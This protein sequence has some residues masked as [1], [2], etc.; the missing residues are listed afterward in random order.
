[1]H[2]N[3]LLASKGL[4]RRRRVRLRPARQ[5]AAEVSDSRVSERSPHQGF[6]DTSRVL[7]SSR[8]NPHLNTAPVIEGG[9]HI[10]RRLGAEQLDHGSEQANR[11]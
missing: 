1:M 9:G 6:R 7:A 2:Q 4:I 11:L 5:A 3:L 8:V 10:E